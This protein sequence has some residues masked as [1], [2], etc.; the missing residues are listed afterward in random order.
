MQHRL[1]S[2][3]LVGWLLLAAA[4]CQETGSIEVHS[5][6]F[7]GT[8]R[9]AAADLKAVLATRASSKLPWGK[10]HAFDRAAF[11]ADLHRIQAYYADRGFA[12]ARVTGVEVTM[13]AAQTRA[14]VTIDIAEGEPTLASAVRFAGVEVLSA[15]AR[16]ALEHGATLK[17]GARLDQTVLLSTREVVLDALRDEGY[18]YARVAIERE[19]TAD[20]KK[21]G[22]V[23]AATPGTKAYV[24]AIDVKGNT[25]VGD[26]VIRRQLLFHTGDLYRR[27]VL[28]DTQRR[29]YDLEL[30]QF[31][32]VQH[33]PTDQ[34][35]ADVPIR[36][37]V[38]EAKHQRVQFSGGYG[39]EE[40]A[41]AEAEWR[42]LNFLGGAR[43]LGVHGKWSSLDRGVRGDLT[44]P[45]FFGSSLSLTLEGHQWYDDEPAYR[46]RSS[47]GRLTLTDHAAAHT[48]F[49]LTFTDEFESSSISA[50]ALGDPTLRPLLIALG[51]DPLTGEQRG[52]LNA[53]A[54]SALRSTAAN[55][56]NPAN[57]YY[58]SGQ[59]EQAGR[60]IGGTFAYTAVSGE[61]R[62]YVP[63]PG[64]G[65]F[66]VRVSYGTIR[67]SGGL[68]ANVPFFRRTFLGGAESLRGWGRYEV[69]PLSD[70]LPVGGFTTLEATLEARL[71]V[72]GKV[73]L[74]AF[75]DAG[76][77]WSDP[78]RVHLGDLRYDVGP[79]LRY[80]T[81]VGP[82]RVDVG[83]QLNPLPGLLVNGAAQTRRWR[84][85]FSIGQAF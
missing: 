70:G 48:T 54:L 32:T 47:G 79:G 30:F 11:E 53:V 40:K 39:T 52:T 8:R 18:P 33:V 36:V 84:I 21:V 27:R 37:T 3:M 73:G 68:D 24:G 74:V 62:A 58:L 55:P 51:L 10:P 59:V 71:R 31:A 15:R 78:W 72:S 66:A 1:R 25:S 64:A 17:V 85:H 34:Q 76:N 44:Q 65:V 5:I 41:R 67:P 38:A 43:S 2:L 63:L 46:V 50:A 77:V 19:P 75:L 83:Y 29:L 57:G 13:N 60:W 49:A 42:H 82:L 22:V 12:D 28:L 81:P 80:D 14:D 7:R 9:I 4:A 69:S 35:P 16:L 6:T 56:L 23:F 45:Y 26:D 61:G 20:A